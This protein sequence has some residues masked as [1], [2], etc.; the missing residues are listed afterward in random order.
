MIRA[1]FAADEEDGIGYKGSIPWPHN[2]ADLK[3]FRKT[4][5]G[6]IVIMGRYTWEDPKMPK[7]LPNRYN[8]VVSSRAIED[9]PNIVINIKQVNK[10]LKEINKKPVWIIGGASLLSYCVPY[11]TELWISRI[12][13]NYNCDTFLP[14]YKKHFWLR[15]E[16]EYNA[17]KIEKW[18]NNETIS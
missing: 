14:D 16:I 15:Q 10:V 7:P 2:S 8:I 17:L 3:W 4:T 6:S 18:R 1:I 5:Q 12:S 11:C 13:G 9:G